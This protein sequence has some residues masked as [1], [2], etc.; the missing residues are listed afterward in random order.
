MYSREDLYELVEYLNNI[1]ERLH[2]DHNSD[3]GGCLYVSWV[4][5]SELEKRRINY[6]VVLYVDDTCKTNDVEMI[7]KNEELW[8]MCISVS[9]MEIDGVDPELMKDEGIKK[10]KTKL[11][12]DEIL[13]LYDKYDFNQVYDRKSDEIVRKEIV[14]CF[15]HVL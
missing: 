11:S 7:L 9:K 15:E 6:S 10:F 1:I 4:V 3:Q 2:K 5:A 8:H 12:S 14:D 13:K